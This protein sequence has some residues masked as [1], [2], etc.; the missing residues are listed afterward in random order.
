M[1]RLRNLR[2]LVVVT[3]VPAHADL[4]AQRLV[5]PYWEASVTSGLP[6]W[7]DEPEL[8]VAASTR[9]TAVEGLRSRLRV[10]GF[11]GV[12]HVLYPPRGIGIGRAP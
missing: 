10:A 3:Y 9:K 12:M 4:A 7:L 5:E 8:A 1:D 2:L 6:L 11:S